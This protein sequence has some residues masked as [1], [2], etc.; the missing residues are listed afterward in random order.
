D[1]KRTTANLCTPSTNVVMNGE[2]KTRHCIDSTSETYHG[3]QWVT[4]EIEVRGNE[5][6]RHIID[7]KTVL[8]YTEPQLDERDAVAKKLMAAGAKKMLS[9]GYISLQ[10][11][12]HP[13]E[14]R[15]IELQKLDP[16]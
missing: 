12:S 6:I 2:L 10:A 7:G 1:S 13:T 5:I 16:R 9:E 15:K 4:V 11:E 3:D 14:F 8:E